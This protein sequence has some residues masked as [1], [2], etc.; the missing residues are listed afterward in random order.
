M[1]DL[2]IGTLIGIILGLLG[3]SLLKIALIGASIGFIVYLFSE[4]SV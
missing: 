1:T 2:I 3:F 4:D